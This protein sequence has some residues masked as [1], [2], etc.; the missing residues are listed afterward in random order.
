MTKVD[1]VADMFAPVVSKGQVNMLRVL[2]G[3]GAFKGAVGAEVSSDDV[4]MSD[5]ASKILEG[6]PPSLLVGSE[7]VPSD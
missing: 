3:F 7:D 6:A 1:A 4:F 5:V 2:G